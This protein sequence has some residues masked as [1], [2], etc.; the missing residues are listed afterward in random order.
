MAVAC[1]LTTN[2]DHAK[3]PGSV[4]KRHIVIANNYSDG[5]RHIGT[6]GRGIILPRPSFS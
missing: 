1:S 4:K 5:E 2:H 3:T 6:K